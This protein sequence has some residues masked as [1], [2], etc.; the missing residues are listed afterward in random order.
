MKAKD[1]NNIRRAGPNG[2]F[3]RRRNTSFSKKHVL[4]YLL[5]LQRRLSKIMEVRGLKLSSSFYFADIDQLKSS[6][7]QQIFAEI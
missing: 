4:R 1:G 2:D 6:F 7:K 3:I 5:H